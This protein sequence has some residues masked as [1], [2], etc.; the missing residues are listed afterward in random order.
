M[1]KTS[2][3]VDGALIGSAADSP[4][5]DQFVLGGAGGDRRAAAPEA[6]DYQDLAIYRSAWTP[7][8]AAA[9]SHGELQQASMEICAP[10]ADPAPAVGAVLENRAQSFSQVLLGTEKFTAHAKAE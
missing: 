1:K 6:A 7:E 8:E 3:Y 2:I 4:I 10:L 9:Q 5:P